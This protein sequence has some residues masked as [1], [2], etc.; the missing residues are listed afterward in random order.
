MPRHHTHKFWGTY[1]DDTGAVVQKK[2]ED[3]LF[4][5]INKQHKS[6]KFTIEQEGDYNSLPML[7]IQ[8]IQANDSI[9]TDIYRKAT[10]TDQYL[11]WTSNHS[12]LKKLGIV[13]MLMHHA[14]RDT[15]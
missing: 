13:R 2:H 7:D 5:N 11:Q 9:T 1:V 4:E 12:V 6:I 15:D 10:H 8:M 14:C 3:E